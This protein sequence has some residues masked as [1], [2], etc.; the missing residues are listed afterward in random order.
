MRKFISILKS[1]LFRSAIIMAFAVALLTA[2]DDDGPKGESNFI[3]DTVDYSAPTADVL[4]IVSDRPAYILPYDY[5]NF[6]AA[7][8]TRMQNKVA[9]AND[10]TIE[11]LATVVLHS[12]QIR[13]MVNEWEVILM[14]LLT[15]RNIIII[16]PTIEDFKYFC[17]VI[18][19][20]YVSMSETEE[21]QE[22]LDELDVIPGARPT[23]EAFHEM[24]LDPTKIESMFVLDTD[25]GGVFAE[26]I[27]IRGS[28]FHIIDRMHGVAV[29]ETTR[30]Q[31]VDNNGK[32][33]IVKSDMGENSSN[34]TSSEEIT[35][36]TYGIFAD[37]LTKWINDQESY[38]DTEDHM[39]KRALKGLNSRA[40]ETTKYNLEDISTVQK[41][42]YTMSVPAPENIGPILPVTVQ[43][44]ICS[45][46][47]KDE[48]CD[49]Y[50]I[51]KNILSYNQVLNCGPSGEANKRK[52]RQNEK[53]GHFVYDNGNKEWVT[54]KYYGPFMRDIESRS[55]CHVHTDDFAGNT[56]TAIDLPHAA[57]VES[58]PGVVVEK[59]SPKNSIGSTDRTD[60]FSYGF[61]GGFC[62]AKEPSVN[63]GFSIGWDAST[64]QT[65]DDLNII[66][67]T[68]NG[69]PEWKYVG[70]NLPESYYNLIL[71]TS[72]SEAPSI[73][74][75]QC[76][77]DQSWIWRV[78]NP[79]GSYRLYDETKVST[80]VMY[81]TTEFLRTNTEY[82]TNTTTKRVSFLMMPPPRS[83]QY[84]MMNVTPWSH[85]V[86]TMLAETHNRF[87]NA[88]NQEFKLNDT[89]DDS[90]ISIEQFINDFQQDLD[91]KRATW[92]NRS[93]KGTYTFS[94]YNINDQ[95][96]EPI[97]FDFVL[98]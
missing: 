40:S 67:S 72:H 75:Q 97:T 26:A 96:K 93:F 70:Q 32:T 54:Y 73:L 5:Q 66:A 71:E 22:L 90:R 50:C 89:S 4:N 79:E 60:G 48:D 28:D 98:N 94:F 8:V 64:T 61:D 21:G 63:L 69:T 10:D 83:Q 31:L 80:C 13:S 47:L 46:Y 43:F 29:S 34:A 74:R 53:F 85:R 77:V 82:R 25:N 78:P 91:R 1:G 9:M 19:T 84:W 20:T 59:Y 55:K 36:Y 15:G 65:I 86:N 3:F 45:I 23:L 33:E 56:N 6:G 76:E 18:T 37:M 81:F 58:A 27:A 11:D 39:R 68:L 30:E 44:E 14:Q 52:W 12:S 57:K 2:C 38:L 95:N 87:W 24:S 51:Y 7:L 17:D 49:Y 92:I 62:W 41:V 35:P 42:Q 88:D 16:E